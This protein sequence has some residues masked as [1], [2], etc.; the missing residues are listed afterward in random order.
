MTATIPAPTPKVTRIVPNTTSCHMLNTLPMAL[1]TIDCVTDMAIIMK[2]CRTG[3]R[4]VFGWHGGSERMIILTSSNTT[5]Y[6]SHTD[7]HTGEQHHFSL[8]PAFP[9]FRDPSQPA[10]Q[11]VKMEL[12]ANLI[13]KT[14]SRMIW[15]DLIRSGKTPIYNYTAPPRSH[16]PN[17]GDWLTV[18]L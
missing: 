10:P 9:S 11:R 14:Y 17:L 3:V 18:S 13:S 12:I 5:V 16:I 1:E 8:A 4:Y 2:P 7:E 6:L 15:N